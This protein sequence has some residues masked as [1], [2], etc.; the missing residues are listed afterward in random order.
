MDAVERLRNIILVL[1]RL[2]YVVRALATTMTQV[3]RVRTVAAGQDA[4]ATAFG[5]QP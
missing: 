5:V 1:N 4:T 3:N 2:A